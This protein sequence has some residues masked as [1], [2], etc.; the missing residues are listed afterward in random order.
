MGDAERIR[1]ERDLYRRL[2]DL[3]AQREIEPFLKEALELVVET[4]GARRGYLEL[5]E[6][7]LQGDRTYA[8]AHGLDGEGLEAVKRAI[9]RG[10]IA[11]AVAS[12]RSVA[13]SSALLDPR[14]EGRPSVQA[15]RIEAVLCAPIGSTPPVGVLYLE[16]RGE[17]G[18]WPDADRELAER[19]ALYL[20]PFAERLIERVCNARRSDP[21]AELRRRF[22][23]DGVVGRSAAL[24]RVLQDAA[25]VAPV[26]VHVLITGESGTGKTQL[27]HVL[28][29]NSPR[30][31]GP[32]V[33]LNCAT[34]P[35][36]LMESELFGARKGAHST[37]THDLP[38]K[39]HAAE[40]GTLFLD[41]IGELSPSAQAKLLHLLQ[42]RE[43]YPL[44]ATRPDKSDVR[45]VAATNSDLEIAVRERSFRED[46]YFRLHVLPIRMPSLRERR[47]DIPALATHFCEEARTRHRLP[48][49]R[50]ARSALV[51]LA[52]AEWPGNVRQL[53][54]AVEA[55]VIRASAESVEQAELRHFFPHE[56]AG[57]GEAADGPQT[58]QDA[59]RRFQRDLLARTLASTEWN[60]SETARTLDL[61][62]AHAYNLINAFELKRQ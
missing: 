1:R 41:E 46:L 62:R 37:A 16:G 35:E 7:D 8:L 51:A 19:F 52:T 15:A 29:Q 36:A 34:L 9:S 43:F 42:S 44:G 55:A 5:Q 33:Q 57:A 38:G 56:A 10:I 59:T 54:H 30:S 13:T 39:V 58:F 22:R 28:H 21:T 45:I 31:K 25:V 49:L 2:L 47:D 14:F 20:A 61:S 32:F 53:A 40:S 4:T 48:T 3:G 17:P 24:A 26:D 50:I 23:L 27:A 60:V 18:P 11:E 12:G 6:E